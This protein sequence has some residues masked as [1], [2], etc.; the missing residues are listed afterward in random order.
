[1]GQAMA[2][3]SKQDI[4]SNDIKTNDFNTKWQNMK[5]SDKVALII[6]IQAAFRGFKARMRVKR[7]LDA[8]GFHPG[9]G[10]YQGSP[11]GAT[12]Y[13]NPDV[14]VLSR[15]LIIFISKLENS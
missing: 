3:C 15:S 6:R 14:M 1:M 4:D 10:H 9:M 11:D 7:L 13:E 8:Q 2:C 12:N 5:H